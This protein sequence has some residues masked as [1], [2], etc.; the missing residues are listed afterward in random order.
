MIITGKVRLK[1]LEESN[2]IHELLFSLGYKYQTETQN[3]PKTKP[4]GIAWFNVG[5]VFLIR[6]TNIKDIFI[7]Y[8]CNESKFDKLFE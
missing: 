6:K 1:T 7:Q 4:Y 2:K 5:D 8:S 3:Y